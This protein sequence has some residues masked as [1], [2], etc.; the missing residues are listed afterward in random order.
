MRG[1]FATV[2]LIGA[3][4][5]LIG[6]LLVGALFFVRVSA[7]VAAVEYQVDGRSGQVVQYEKPERPEGSAQQYGIYGPPRHAVQVKASLL[8]VIALLL[9]VPAGLI[10]LLIVLARACRGGGARV[11]CERSRSAGQMRTL[12]ELRAGIGRMAARVESLETILLS[13]RPGRQ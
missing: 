5:V 10:V 2:L 9:L 4:F 8:G 11:Q 12:E 7:P 13:A 1:C 6:A 3:L